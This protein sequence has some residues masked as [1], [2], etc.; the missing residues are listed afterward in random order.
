MELVVENNPALTTLEHLSANLP[1][2]HRIDVRSVGLR[3]NPL[4]RDI[5][6]LR[7]V[8]NVS[9][10]SS[11]QPV[12]GRCFHFLSLSLSV[13]MSVQACYSLTDLSG[14]DNLVSAGSIV[15]AQLPVPSISG[16]SSLFSA[17]N[18]WLYRN[19]VSPP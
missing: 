5:D 17:S 4:L 2:S 3:N 13:L 19:E 7:I 15:L 11:L 1:S 16:F 6:G 8:T 10:R 12:K 9:G 14:L 18:L